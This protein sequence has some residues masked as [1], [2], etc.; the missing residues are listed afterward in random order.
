M[1]IMAV[2]CRNVLHALHTALFTSLRRDIT[3]CW[4]N[5]Q[6]GGKLIAGPLQGQSLC[7]FWKRNDPSPPPRRSNPAKRL[8]SRASVPAPHR[9]LRQPAAHARDLL[10]TAKLFGQ[11]PSGMCGQTISCCTLAALTSVNKI[12]PCLPDSPCVKRTF[13]S[14]FKCAPKTGAHIN[15]PVSRSAA[16]KYLHPPTCKPTYLPLYLR[17]F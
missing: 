12:F 1:Y 11:P 3:P 10:C 13:R 17:P 15:S 2:A 9:A 6:L 4:C 7:C 14:Y 16:Y 8:N 5:L